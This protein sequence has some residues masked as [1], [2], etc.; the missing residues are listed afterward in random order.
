MEKFHRYES[1]LKA[2][3]HVSWTFYLS[4][5]R[6]IEKELIIDIEKIKS[7]SVL[8]QLLIQLESKPSFK[9]RGKSDQSNI[10]SGFQKLYKIYRRN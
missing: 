7:H 8:K 6:Q 1:W 3:N 9:A 4:F 10:L 5:M 2:N